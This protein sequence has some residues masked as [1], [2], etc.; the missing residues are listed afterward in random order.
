[1]ITDLEDGDIGLL[2]AVLRREKHGFSCT[3][4]PT[5][6]THWK[7]NNMRLSKPQKTQESKNLE[8]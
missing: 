8:A 4:E 5:T 7:E 1:M 3:I 2:I 6:I